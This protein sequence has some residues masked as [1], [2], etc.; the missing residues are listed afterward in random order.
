VMMRKTYY[1][2]DVEAC[3]SVF[4]IHSMD[5]SIWMLCPGSHL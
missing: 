2:C 3:R 1:G 4:H 5:K